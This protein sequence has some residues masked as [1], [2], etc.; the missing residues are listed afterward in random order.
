MSLT[1]SDPITHF[2]GFGS[3]SGRL[4][5]NGQT[6]YSAA[7]DMLCKLMSWYRQQR[8]E[9]HAVGFH[10]HPWDGVGMAARPDTEAILKASNLRLMPMQTGIQH[11]LRELYSKSAETELMITDYEYHQRYYGN[12]VRETAKRNDLLGAPGQRL[13]TA[14]KA[15]SP[16]KPAGKATKSPV[17]QIADRTLMRMVDAPLAGPAMPLWHR[18]LRRVACASIA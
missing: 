10:F 8:P 5:S 17:K 7:S 6:D 1:Q 15:A 11:L 14:T 9:V 16:A 13:P 3:I 12:G 18:R 2:I 4:G